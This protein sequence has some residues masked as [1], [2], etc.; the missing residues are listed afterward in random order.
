M[1]KTTIHVVGHAHARVIEAPSLAE[2]QAFELRDGP[3]THA[4]F[5]VIKSHMVREVRVSRLGYSMI[6]WT[7]TLTCEAVTP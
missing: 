1:M 7:Q 6:E 3:H 4:T 5:T 2:G